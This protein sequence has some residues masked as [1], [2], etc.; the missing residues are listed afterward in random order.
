MER[1]L[2]G[3]KRLPAKKL[4]WI[5][6]DRRFESYPL[7]RTSR[8]KYLYFRY[9]AFLFFVLYPKGII[10]TDCPI[11]AFCV[12]LNEDSKMGIYL[13]ENGIYYLKIKTDGK[14][15]RISL[16][17]SDRII[18]QEIYNSY[19]LDKMK[20]KIIPDRYLQNT[21]YML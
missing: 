4:S 20:S 6:R 17:T 21:I 3:R 13:R 7:R 12:Y 14:Y 11:W 16:E 10:C 15:K 1:W 18:A 9:L 8:A 5:L 2:S 19:L